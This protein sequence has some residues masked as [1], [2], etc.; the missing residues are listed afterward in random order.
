M[1]PLDTYHLVGHRLVNDD[2]GFGHPELIIQQAE[3]DGV[4]GLFHI[5]CV[6]RP[7]QDFKTTIP[8]VASCCSIPC[9]F[10]LL[11]VAPYQSIIVLQTFK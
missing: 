9:I 10:K 1:L 8:E 2:C 6:E 4:F 3:R 5:R 7:K 11:E